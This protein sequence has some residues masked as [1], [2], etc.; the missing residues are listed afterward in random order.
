[1][2]RKFSTWFAAGETRQF[3]C[4]SNCFRYKRRLRPAKESES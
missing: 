3:A 1:M 2:Q 4:V